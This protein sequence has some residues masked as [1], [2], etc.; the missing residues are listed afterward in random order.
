[1]DLLT[2]PVLTSFPYLLKGAG[3]TLLMAA[4][5]IVPSTMLGFALA[6]L[7]I[8]G[9]SAIRTVILVYLFVV[10]GIPLLVLIF[11]MYYVL[12]YAGIDLTPF[13]GVVLVL[14]VYFSAF[15]SEVFRA[16]IESLPKA[17]WDAAK[18]LGMRRGLLLRTIILPQALL[19]SI[20]PYINICVGLVKGTSLASIVGLWELTQASREV[21]ER[22][23]APGQILLGAAALYFI[24]CY[25]LASFGRYVERVNL[26]SR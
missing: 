12:P 10:R 20:P 17:Q 7:H 24:M 11:F 21:L 13:W 2:Y 6:F 18:G 26:R 3:M 15:M 9:G 16:G 23:L 14:A 5:A 1:M 19:L 22:T 25:T 4:T 8:F